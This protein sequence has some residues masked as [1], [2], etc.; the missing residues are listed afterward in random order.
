MGLLGTAKKAGKKIYHG[1]ADLFDDFDVSK[2]ADG[3]I[4]FTDNKSKILSG[5]VGAS[6]NGNVME[7]IID[8]DK[9]KLATWDDTDKYST[10]QLID[11]GFD[12]VKMVED[13]E[14]TYQIFNPEK[15]SKVESLNKPQGL[16]MDTPSRMA[17]AKEQGFDVD[18][19]YYHASKQ[20]ISEFKA[21]YDD[22]LTFLT[23]N[24][25]FANK[26]LGKGKFNQRQGEEESIK[27]YEQTQRD[28]RK[29]FFD[30]DEL[31]KL[32]SGPEFN[33]LY[34]KYQA[35]FRAAKDIDSSDLHGTVY[36]VNTKTKNTFIPHRDG[37]LLEELMGK[38]YM[39][40]GFSPS[41]GLPT[42]RDA[43]KDGSYLMYENPQVV[44]FL[45]SKGFDSMMLKESSGSKGY[46]TMA[47]FDPQDIRSTNAAFDPAKTGSSNLLASNP[48]ATAGAGILGLGAAAQSN[49]TYADYSPSNLARL[50]S[51]DVGG[52]QAPQS[53]AASNIAGLMGSINKVGYDDPLLGM[54]AS[55]LPS[56][57]MNKIAYN[58]RRGLLDYAK[59]YAGLLGF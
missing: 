31:D 51:S 42:T 7:R 35:D 4:W 34:D 44:D 20:D 49:D 59:A 47:V 37:D 39:D 55:Q 25:E 43:Y 22:G 54:V 58:D 50:Q 19:P 10:G 1:T 17:R 29:S 26:W 38:E 40:A 48:V 53:M 27:L 14:N 41:D 56:E 32:P 6:T 11:Q 16:L 30:F 13:G 2:S 3:S 18:T 15:L 5:D 21:G 36:P 12:G 9:L 45:K 8:E 28:L 24:P 52:Y 33:A 23:P 57:L 46:S